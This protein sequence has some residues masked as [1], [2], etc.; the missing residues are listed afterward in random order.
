MP[1]VLVSTYH[2]ISLRNVIVA[3]AQAI[4]ALG[5]VPVQQ[6]ITALQVAAAIIKQFVAALLQGETSQR[7]LA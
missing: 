2:A 5:L 4:E 6:H 7:H 3:S 1:S